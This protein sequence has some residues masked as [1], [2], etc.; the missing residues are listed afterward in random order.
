M[1]KNNL[2]F[3][4]TVRREFG[5]NQE[6]LGRNV[7][8]RVKLLRRIKKINNRSFSTHKKRSTVNSRVKLL[9]QIDSSLEKL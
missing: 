5:S 1:T 3:N 6:E 4:H 2:Y 7:Q 9:K 8:T